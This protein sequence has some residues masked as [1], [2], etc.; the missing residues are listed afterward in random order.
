MKIIIFGATGF[1]GSHVAEQAAL[2]GHDVNCIV[3][4]GSNVSFL[5]SLGVTITPVNFSDDEQILNVLS[6][7]AVVHNC[8]ADTRPHAS[9]AERKKIDIDM[10]DK[11]FTLSQKAGVKRFI[12]L[13]TI[14]A[15]GFD[16]PSTAIDETYTP[17]PKYIYSQVACDREKH[18]LDLYQENSTEL[19]LVR[20]SNVI[21]KR[22]ISFLPNFVK[23]NRQGLFPVVGGGQW[24][25][26]CMDARD[27]GRAMLH[28]MTVSASKPEIFLVKG[29]DIEWLSFKKEL[30]TFLGRKTKVM[31]L[32]KGLVMV[33]GR[34]ME[35]VYPYGSEP[36]MTRFQMEVLS[37]NG[38]FDDSK[39]KATG[40]ETQYSLLDSFQDAEIKR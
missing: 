34:I 37:Y 32:P 20:P 21:G 10:A 33:I 2:A 7:G 5:E 38:L 12:Q 13:S 29:F 1:L 15:Y 9:Y 8:I 39:I 35:M 25:F 14:M 18:L 3:R 19:V 17:K 27:V 6:E 24:S 16:R 30:D 36:P 23:S 40:F 31:N 11:L 26:S 22:D 28:L 4:Q